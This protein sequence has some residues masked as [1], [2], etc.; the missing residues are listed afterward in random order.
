MRRLTLCAAIAAIF[1]STIIIDQGLA[2]STTSN[3]D[4][5]EESEAL[6]AAQ[7][8]FQDQRMAP[9]L[10]INPNAFASVQAQVLALPTIGSAWTERT[11]P[12]NGVDFSDSP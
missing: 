7:A 3:K 5:G 11:S 2:A 12:V 6:G 8:W 1:V 4:A 10:S 9:N